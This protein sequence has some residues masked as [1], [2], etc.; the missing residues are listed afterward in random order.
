MSAVGEP[1][2]TLKSL[3]FR[4][5]GCNHS[6]CSLRL[7]RRDGQTESA[8]TRL[9]NYEDW[10]RERSHVHAVVGLILLDVIRLMLAVAMRNAVITNM[11]R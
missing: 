8:D 1:A 6:Q 5:R 9:V 2:V 4:S 7:L 11:T 10:S 3:F